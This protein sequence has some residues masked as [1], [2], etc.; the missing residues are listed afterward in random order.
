MRGRISRHQER[1]TGCLENVNVPLVD[2]GALGRHSYTHE[3]WESERDGV[4]REVGQDQA[5]HQEN[6]GHGRTGLPPS[7]ETPPDQRLPYVCGPHL[8]VDEPVHEG[9]A[10]DHRQLVTSQGA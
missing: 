3:R 7:G 10:F 9:A 5:A 2:T 6:G 4:S 1:S 8:P